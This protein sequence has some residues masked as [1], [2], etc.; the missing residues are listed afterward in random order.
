MPLNNKIQTHIITHCKHRNEAKNIFCRQ[1][2]NST[3]TKVRRLHF[4]YANLE[5]FWKRLISAVTAINR[6]TVHSRKDAG[7]HRLGGF[8]GGRHII[9]A[10]MSNS[11]SII[12]TSS[13]LTLLFFNHLI[14]SSFCRLQF[15]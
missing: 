5:L 8:S 12:R 2:A 4:R 11:Q 9:K 10:K 15:L 7:G 14:E 1:F 13:D 6:V 3:N